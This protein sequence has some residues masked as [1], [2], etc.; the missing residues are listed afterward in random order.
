MT[1]V[2]VG[3]ALAFAGCGHGSSAAQRASA[4]RSSPV[5]VRARLT[6]WL[7]PAPVTGEVALASQGRL[8]VIGGLDSSGS[9]GDG[10]VSIDPATGDVRT[11]GSLAQP[12]HDAAGA[13]LGRSA[14]VFG[15]GEATSY[16]G[17][18]EL[19]PGRQAGLVGSLPAARSDLGAAT[20]AGRVYLLGGYDGATLAA[21][22]L[23][24]GDGRRF[25]RIAGLPVPVRYPAVA[26]AGGRVFAFGG[27][28]A[29][30]AAT[31]A[32]QE[33]VPSSGRAKVVASLPIAT[34]HAAAVGLGNRIYV[35][36]GLV[37]GSPSRQ[38]TSFDP[39]TDRVKRLGRLPVA[40]ADAAAVRSGAAGYLIGGLDAGQAPSSRVI[41]LTAS[42]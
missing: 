34:D 4:K 9:S 29:N 22:V 21:D 42:N 32:I 12:T 7:L 13:V 31:D 24:T 10:V 41:R 38:I 3:V 16:S 35:L 23:A 33:V 40:V 17:V 36:G 26:A 14:F 1:A 39:V 6:R 28:G 25:H 2:T 20:I 19:A 30:G 8:L 15:G 5:V 27:E 18:E 11:Q 37:A